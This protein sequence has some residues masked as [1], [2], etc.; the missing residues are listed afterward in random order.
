[1]NSNYNATLKESTRS[2]KVEVCRVHPQSTAAPHL[3]LVCCPS[4][5]SG[6]WG[7]TGRGWTP[8]SPHG[9]RCGTAARTARPGCSWGRS[10]PCSW[11][12]WWT[13]PSASA[14]PPCWSS[15]H[16]TGHTKLNEDHVSETVAHQGISLLSS[17][18][19]PDSLEVVLHWLLLWYKMRQNP[20][21]YIITDRCIFNTG[22]QHV[23][24]GGQEK[25]NNNNN[26]TD[27]ADVNGQT[28]WACRRDCTHNL[29]RWSEIQWEWE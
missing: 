4:R 2:S 24:P 28:V 12:R 1:M 8:E 26:V 10:T 5:A 6:R 22:K 18:T 21:H 29:Q 17:V 15:L 14:P 11:A 19:S 9:S 3:L 20:F 23:W 27:C 25:E 16:E 7:W 13:P